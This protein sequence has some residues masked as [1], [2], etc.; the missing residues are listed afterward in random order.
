MN[1]IISNTPLLFRLTKPDIPCS[2]WED[3]SSCYENPCTYCFDWKS[4]VETFTTCTY[5][6]NDYDA[7]TCSWD[8]PGCVIQ[9]RC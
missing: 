3:P 8:Y 1:T 4:C 6:S 5:C 9:E 2:Y 7:E